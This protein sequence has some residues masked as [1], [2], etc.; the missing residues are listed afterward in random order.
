M[1]VEAVIPKSKC[2]EKIFIP[3][4]IYGIIGNPIGHS[5]SPAVHNHGFQT[6]GLKSVYLKWEV[7]SDSLEDFITAARTLPISG[8]SVTIPHKE[9]IMPLVDRTTDLAAKVGAVN[10][11][12]WE[13]GLLMGHNTD[14]AGFTAPIRNTGIKP[15]SALVLGAGGAS[16][17]VLAG[18]SELGVGKIA[19]CNRTASKAQ[20]LAAEFN[21]EFV[22]WEERADSEYDLVVNT[23]SLG[24]Q[25]K[26]QDMN[27]WPENAN[28]K[29]KIAYDI[30]YNPLKTNF[31]ARAEQNGAQII[32]GLEMFIFQA[33]HQ[34]KIWTGTELDPD[35]LRILLLDLLHK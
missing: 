1:P 23:T 14:V 19:I 35:D 21:A 30:V 7:A 29:I 9:R 2:F 8:A 31:L 6:Q 13:D 33:V 28:S 5:L 15:A 24:M 22:A 20:F 4:K 16:R 34:F 27:P 25:G 11:L 12:Y 17:A 32:N 26:F 3:E 10:T 18:L